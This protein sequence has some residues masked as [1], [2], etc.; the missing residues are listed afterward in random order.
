MLLLRVRKLHEYDHSH[1]SLLKN[2]F[3]RGTVI[4]IY[5]SFYVYMYL[6]VNLYIH[7]S[8]YLSMYLP[9]LSICIFIYLPMYLSVNLLSVYVSS[10]SVYLFIDYTCFRSLKFKRLKS[11][12]EGGINGFWCL[13][14]AQKYNNC[15]KGFENNG[16]MSLISWQTGEHGGCKYVIVD[17]I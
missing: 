15:V 9:V 12:Y 4:N 3:D 2:F 6:S 11:K 13:P 16:F 14:N 7:V 17:R 5:S 1:N 10:P 8:V